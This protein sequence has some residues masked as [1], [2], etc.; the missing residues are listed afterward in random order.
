MLIFD[1]D[2]SRAVVEEFL[3]GEEAEVFLFS[4]GRIFKALSPV[5]V[6]GGLSMVIGVRRHKRI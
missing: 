3:Q 4:D 6:M 5:R 2:N 1:P